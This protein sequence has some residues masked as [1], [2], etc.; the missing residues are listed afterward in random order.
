MI[1]S[2]EAKGKI[3]IFTDLDDTLI[4]TKLKVPKN[5]HISLGATNSSGV[6]LSFFTQ[7]QRLMLDVFAKSGAIIIPVT[8][9]DTHALNRVEYKF[10]SF[11]VVSHGAIV[12]MKMMIT[13]QKVG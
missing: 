6:P 12:L 7:S 9:R 4:Q 13:Y 5:A 8:G 3:V 11:R 2:N 1:V 10:T